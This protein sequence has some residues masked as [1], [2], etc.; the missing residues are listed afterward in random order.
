M[1]EFHEVKLIPAAVASSL[2][3]SLLAVLHPDVGAAATS[4]QRVTGRVGEVWDHY[5]VD[6]WGDPAAV[7]SGTQTLDASAD[8]NTQALMGWGA[9]DPEPTPGAFD[10]SSLDYRVSRLTARGGTPVLTLCCSPAWMRG[11]PTGATDWSGLELAPMPGNFADFAALAATAAARYPQIKYFQ[12]WNEMKGFWNP[13]LNRWNYESY[14]ELYNQVYA[15]VRAVRPDA[16]IGGPYVVINSY[17]ANNPAPSTLSGPWGSVDQRDLD[18]VSY[19]LA[20]SAGSQFVTLDISTETRDAGII[21]D[22]QVMAGKVTAVLSWVHARSALPVWFAEFGA[23]AASTNSAATA[24]AELLGL[25]A[26][27]RAGAAMT[28]FW[29][30]EQ[31]PD[32]PCGRCLFTSTLAVG[33]GVASP[34]G[35]LLPYWRSSIAPLPYQRV[36]APAVGVYAIEAESTSTAAPSR[37]I[38]INTRNSSVT[39]SYAGGKRTLAAYATTTSD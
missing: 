14:T 24:G 8:A 38:L 3:F 39:L 32:A 18:A 29:G 13:A 9:G 27:D 22:P 19:W 36:T 1:T 30:P 31:Q 5:T 10:W 15:A 35:R 16:Q 12:I 34:L 37:W 6:S 7:S 21:A 20:H 23:P 33:G 11:D 28:N 4:A 2:A 25:S 17:K 26:A